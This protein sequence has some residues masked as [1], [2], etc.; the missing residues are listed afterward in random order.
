VSVVLMRSRG[1]GLP[2]GRVKERLGSLKTEKAIS[3]IAIH[4]HDIPQEF[5]SDAIREAEAARPA[6][7]P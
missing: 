3:L 2:T 5:P 1:Y 4:A 7:R 6:G